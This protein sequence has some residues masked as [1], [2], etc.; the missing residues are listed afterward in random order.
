MTSQ[1]KIVVD[2]DLANRFKAAVLSKCGKLAISREGARAL[3]LYLAH[4]GQQAP[5]KGAPDPLLQ[6]LGMATS[7]GRGRPDAKR[8]KKALYGL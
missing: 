2:D 7:K 3:E 1:I 4:E 5:P 6:S 8:D